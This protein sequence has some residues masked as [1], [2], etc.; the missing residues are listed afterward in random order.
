MAVLCKERMTAAELKTEL[1]RLGGA[2]KKHR[3]HPED[4]LQEA[5]CKHLDI[6]EA[7]GRLKYFAVPNGGT[8]RKFEAARFKKMGVK[9]GVPDLVILAPPHA[10]FVELKAPL[11]RTSENQEAWIG[12]LTSAGYAVAICRSIDEVKE[13]L[14]RAGVV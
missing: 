5:V 4:D 3:R 6:L 7:Q 14:Q 2:P 12:W 1:H 8:R 13:F 11:G 10:L 9:S